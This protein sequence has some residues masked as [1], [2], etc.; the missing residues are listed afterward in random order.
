MGPAPYLPTLADDET[1][2][3]WC[4]HVHQISCSTCSAQTS[5]ALFGVAS[6]MRQHEIPS[7]TAA[8][9]AL[10]DASGG[11]E[12]LLRNHSIAGAYLPFMS[13]T[14]R[15]RALNAASQGAPF[16][17]RAVIQVSRSRPIEHP[18]RLCPACVENDFKVLGRPL[19]HVAHQLP[20]S[21]CCLA[22]QRLLYFVRTPP[23][24]RWVT[25]EQAFCI[26]R[27][28]DCDL[29]SA[30]TCSAI[31]R[32][33]GRQP[34]VNLPSLV[35]ATQSRLVDIGVLHSAKRVAHQRLTNWFE[36]ASAAQ[37]CK[38]SGSGLVTLADGKWIAGQLWRNHHN[39]AARW[40]VL[41][42]ALGW[43]SSP[44]A[45]SSFVE[46]CQGLVTSACQHA[47]WP[48]LTESTPR[49]PLHVLK[50]IESA[51]SYAEVI[52]QLGCNRG[53]LTRWLNLD[54]RVRLQWKAR[55]E[56]VRLNQILDR[57]HDPE[58]GS[59]TCVVLADRDIRWLKAKRPDLCAQ[60]G[61]KR[62]FQRLLF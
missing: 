18:L 47:L 45:E 62:G 50:A 34:T 8:L 56:Q 2:Y 13:E 5:L 6:T 37:I 29:Q 17:T 57:I 52:E 35:R 25:P 28:I 15:C 44:E 11:L 30:L 55:R 46:A 1:I 26:S 16:W 3:G 20:G 41:W 61:I 43:E 54:D 19:W 39:N 58:T 42:G 31:A 48:Q 40:I 14:A 24:K 4:A 32:A 10:M 59:K 33:A 36:H 27:P 38:A 7:R 9:T 22:H 21:Y 12:N 23:S 53:D 49:L 60:A 51:M